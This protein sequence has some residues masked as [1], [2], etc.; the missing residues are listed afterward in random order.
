MEW[1]TPGCGVEVDGGERV[2]FS[3]AE[4]LIKASADTTNGAFTIVEETAPLDTPPHV[5]EREN[6]L[7][8]VLEG[9]HLIEGA[10]GEFRVGPGGM[11]FRPRGVPHAQRRVAP[12]SGCLLRLFY[13]AGFESFHREL[14]E[15]ERAGTIGRAAYARISKKYG[16]RWPA[17]PASRAHNGLCGM[18]SD[19]RRKQ[20]DLST[21]SAVANTTQ[22]NLR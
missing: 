16:I 4:F 22:A 6:E 11:V 12:R 14:A 15:A 9:E 5:H 7:F 20:L 1:P 13:P 21:A 3:G 10:G 17:Q 2:R 19:A 18:R 8:Y